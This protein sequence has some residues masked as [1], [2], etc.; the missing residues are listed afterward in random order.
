MRTAV[1][2]DKLGGQFAIHPI[3]NKTLITSAEIPKVINKE[4]QE[5]LKAIISRD[6]MP[7][8]QK[9]AD[10]Y[11][12]RPIGTYFGSCN[13]YPQVSG[14]EHG[15]KR[16]VVGIPFDVCLKEGDPARKTDFHKLILDDPDEMNQ[17]LNWVLEGALR[18]VKQRGFSELPARM[19][20]LAKEND[21]M[22]DTVISYMADRSMESSNDV[23]T[24]KKAIYA[25]YV[26]FAKV[27]SGR[28]AVS[29]EE[30]WRRVKEKHQDIQEQ[31]LYHL[32][33]KLRC[34]SLVVDNV[35]T[36]RDGR[37]K[38]GFIPGIDDVPM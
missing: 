37:I 29:V 24:C 13:V 28:G 15:W 33:E 16:K 7:A 17:V 2:L 32:K 21:L 22:T 35:G 20:A 10:P 30:F 1:R 8:E 9:G 11:N 34:V 23:R 27:E 25:D 5:I 31:Q 19:V 12:M 4:T 18:L 14:V 38:D 36:V 26:Q 6:E 3:A